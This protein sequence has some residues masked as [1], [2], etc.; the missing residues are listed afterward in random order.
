MRSILIR[1]CDCCKELFAR[2]GLYELTIQ[3][4]KFRFCSFECL[5]KF[6][7]RENKWFDRIEPDYVNV[8]AKEKGE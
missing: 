7:E 5:T 4:E 6:I 3:L 1:E 8:V 2:A